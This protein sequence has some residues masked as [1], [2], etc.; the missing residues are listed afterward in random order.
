MALAIDTYELGPLGTNCYVVRADRGVAEAVVVDP[1]GDAAQLRLELARM[2]ARCAAI[3]VTHGHFD[4]L[5]GVADLAEGTGAPVYMPEGEREQLETPQAQFGVRAY[6]P[7]VLLTGGE[8]ARGGRD[9]VRGRRPSPA[10]RPRTSPSTPT[11][12]CSRATSCSRAPSAAPTFRAPTG[13]PCSTRSARSSRATRPRP[14]STPATAPRRRSAPSSPA[15]RSSQSCARR[16][17]PS[18]DGHAGPPPGRRALVAARLGDRAAAAALRLRADPDAGDRGHRDDPALLRRRLGHRPEGDL[19]LRRP[20]RPLAHAPPRG[21]RADRARLPRE[22]APPRA[23]AGQ[24]LHDRD[25]VPLRPAAGGP[26]PRAHP[27]QRRDHRLGRPRRRR[28]ADPALRRAAAPLRLHL[29]GAAAQLD[30]RREVQARVP[31]AADRLA[32]RARRRTRRGGAPEAGDEPAPRLRR[33]ERARPGGPAG[34]A[35]D[36]RVALRRVPR[37]LRAR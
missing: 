12:R 25:D 27:A 33:E 17:V 32:R 1:G 19:H 16:E 35:E 2:G 18:A 20:R 21:H 8:T 34:R 6:T 30:R 11:A 29:V 15:T 36:R 14:P 5:G 13:R 3:L 4:H 23:E 10:T 37:A 22:R 26:L 24:A 31:R 7:D 28:G 9:L